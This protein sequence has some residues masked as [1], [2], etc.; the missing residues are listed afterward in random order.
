MIR[1]TD[2]K[3]RRLRN[4]AELRSA[5]AQEIPL[6]PETLLALLDMAE[7]ARAADAASWWEIRVTTEEG[8]AGNVRWWS[9]DGRAAIDMLSIF[10]ANASAPI[11]YS[12]VRCVPAEIERLDRAAKAEGGDPR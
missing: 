5:R 3:L 2:E 12:L 11:G 10:Q 6:T 8:P 4:W 9:R 7:A 1:L